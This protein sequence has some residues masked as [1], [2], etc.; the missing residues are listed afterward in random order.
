M[1]ENGPE[2]QIQLVN[3]LQKEEDLIS[4]APVVVKIL[5]EVLKP[6]VSGN[7]TGSFTVTIQTGT[8]FYSEALARARLV[9][10]ELLAKLA[11]I[12]SNG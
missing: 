11:Q 12:P 7:T 3:A 1:G 4:I 8:V 10:I 6:D 9:A 5:E 2:V